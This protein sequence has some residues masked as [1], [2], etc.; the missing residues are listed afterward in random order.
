MKK[1]GECG[2]EKPLD[3]FH[4]DAR[5]PDGKLWRCK[6]CQNAANRRYAKNV[7]VE[8]KRERWRKGNSSEA[9][10]ARSKRYYERNVERYQEWGREWREHN[11]EH[12]RMYWQDWYAE[13]REEHLARRKAT[14]DPDYK[15]QHRNPET[16]RIHVDARRAKLAGVDAQ[17]IPR[18]EL[19]E[20]DNGTCRICRTRVEPHEWE[21]DHIVP[22]ALGGTHTWN[23]VQATCRPCNRAKHIRLEGQ[24]SLPVG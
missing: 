2:N 24:I 22:I 1:C 23:N 6:P 3:D 11:A 7:P 14:Y 19:Y 18:T 5:S 17:R 4:K 21:L 13:N 20:R 10:Q 12:V 9:G 16:N 8:V 15:R